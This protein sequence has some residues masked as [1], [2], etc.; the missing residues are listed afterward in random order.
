MVHRSK[1]PAPIMEAGPANQQVRATE[2]CTMA[3]PQEKAVGGKL[4]IY[5]FVVDTLEEYYETPGDGLQRWQIQLGEE[6]EGYLQWLRVAQPG[7]HPHCE[8]TL[9]EVTLDP[10]RVSRSTWKFLVCKGRQMTETVWLTA[11]RAWNMPVSRL[12]ADTATRLGLTERPNDWC[13]VRPCNAA[14]RQEDRFLAKV[15]SVLEIA[16]PGY[17]TERRPRELNFCKPDVIIGTRDWETVERFL[18]NVETYKIARLRE[19]HPQAPCTHS[20][21][22]W[23]E[24]VPESAFERD[25]AVVQDHFSGGS[26]AG[27]RERARQVYAPPRREWDGGLHLSGR[28]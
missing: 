7:D 18:C 25:S 19:T 21:A 23:R 13:Q 6:D 2:H 15:A 22:E 8:L 24:M 28:G 12:S 3:F 14:G 4:I 27:Q 9:E 26:Q 11:M 1:L 5:A 16:P 20:A 10:E 17:P